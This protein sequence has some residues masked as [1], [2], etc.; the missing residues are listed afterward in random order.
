MVADARMG[1]DVHGRSAGG[2]SGGTSRVGAPG[3]SAYVVATPSAASVC[4]PVVRGWHGVASDR[5]GRRHGPASGRR[6]ASTLLGGPSRWI[7]RQA[8]A[9]AASPARPR[10][11]NG[12]G[13]GRDVRERRDGPDRGV[14]ASG[15]GRRDD[16][17]GDPDLCVAGR[18]D[19][20]R[21]AHRRD[22][23]AGLAEPS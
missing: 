6:V 18:P 13:C 19:P 15:P 23:S 14:D 11:A 7:G 22:P 9:G 10:R 1:A 5:A 12:V 4:D 17:N 8:A 21:D 20:Q 16:R 2:H 3:A